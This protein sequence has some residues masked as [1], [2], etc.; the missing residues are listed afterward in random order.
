MGRIPAAHRSSRL[1]MHAHTPGSRRF[2]PIFSFV[3][4]DAGRCRLSAGMRSGV[5]ECPSEDYYA[6]SAWL[7]RQ[8]MASDDAIVVWLITASTDEPSRI[9]TALFRLRSYSEDN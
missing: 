7:R 3:E 1:H 6:H 8:R 4:T 2:Q 5:M 9:V